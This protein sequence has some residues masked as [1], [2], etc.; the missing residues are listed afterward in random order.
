MD[1][2]IIATFLI[3]YIFI[4]LEGKIRINKAAIALLTGCLCWTI[5]IL[6]T[7]NKE[8]VIE[9]LADELGEFLKFYFF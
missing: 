4:A 9:Q 7:V 8:L 1:S 2:L 3:G 5:Y 6:F